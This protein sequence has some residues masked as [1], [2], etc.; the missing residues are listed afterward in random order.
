MNAGGPN[1][2]FLGRCLFWHEKFTRLEPFFRSSVNGWIPIDEK[3]RQFPPFGNVFSVDR[4][5]LRCVEGAARLFRVEANS[6]ILSDEHD[7][8]VAVDVQV[9]VEI[10]DLSTYEHLDDVRRM[11]VE[12]GLSAERISSQEAVIAMKGRLCVRLRFEFD[13]TDNVWRPA[14][15]RGLEQLTIFR[16]PPHQLLT[17]KLDGRSYFCPTEPLQSIDVVDWSSDPEF[18]QRVL[19]RLKKTAAFQP[20]GDLSDIS[21]RTI[22]R[23]ATALRNG[24]PLGNDSRSSKAMTVR[25]QAFVANLEAN[26]NA[27]HSVVDTLLSLPFVEGELRK[28]KDSAVKKVEH[29]LR[30]TLGPKVRQEIVESLSQLTAARESAAMELEEAHAQLASVRQDMALISEDRDRQIAALG[31]QSTEFLGAISTALD[32]AKRYAPEAK[33]KQVVPPWINPDIETGKPIKLAELKNAL[34]DSAELSGVKFD[35]LIE[36]DALLRAGEIPLLFGADADRLLQVYSRSVAAGNIWRMSVDLATLG[37]DDLWRHAATGEP[38]AFASA[39]EAAKGSGT[40]ILVNIEDLTAAPASHWFP[41]LAHFARTS[42]RPPNLFISATVSDTS[43]ATGRVR[44]TSLK[45]GVPFEVA[46]TAGG[47]A[48]AAYQAIFHEA[49]GP[50]LELQGPILPTC[51]EDMIADL[52]RELLEIGATPILAQRAVLVFRASL[53]TMQPQE[54]RKLSLEIPKLVVSGPSTEGL[55]SHIESSFC[56]LEELLAAIAKP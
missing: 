10:V 26:V 20:Q 39:W 32:I 42:A 56:R 27:V 44:F 25:L 45:H 30:E 11:I 23:L 43:I 2:L 36:L 4:N 55:L 16:L 40:P 46:A 22:E 17:A 54:A 28:A 9:P 13:A 49:R 52:S 15:H 14:D 48:A 47:V 33:L 53:A 34:M 35:D 29:E 7:H 37:I 50:V 38:T 24:E 21:R 31:S 5:A 41:Q 19:K 6:R 18:F 1:S 3:K 8:F 12:S 51:A